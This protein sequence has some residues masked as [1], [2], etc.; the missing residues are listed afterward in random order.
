MAE[1]F[2]D[3][4]AR[5]YRRADGTP[6]SELANFKLSIRVLRELYGTTT[7]A[8]FSP[9]KLK[10]VRNKMIETD[11]CRGVINQRIGRIKSMFKWAVQEE[12]IPETVYRALEC[13]RGIPYGRGE[14]RETE[15]VG[16]VPESYVSA[17]K[18]H[19]LPTVS[20]MI[21]IQRLT[22]MRPGEVCA[23]RAIDIETSGTVWLYRPSQHKTAWRG[24]KRVIALGPKAQ[25]IVREFLTT[26]TQSHLFSPRRAI[27]EHYAALRAERKSKVQPSQASRA[28]KQPEIEPG[29]CY[30]NESY[31]RAI[32]R[33]CVKADDAAREEA[34]KAALRAG[35]D[36]PNEDVVFVPHWHPNQLRHLHATEVRRQFG[37]EAA[38]VTLGHSQ[39][40]V[41]EIYAE[42]N[43]GLAVQVASKIG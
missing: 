12:I 31:A 7:A 21:E 6:T 32:A 24:R 11:L 35:D 23:M 39:A 5:Y 42:R 8:A 17:I 9:L 30:T 36:P 38:Q 43:L 19:V 33:G 28:K 34:T 15:P 3:R 41:T 2:L 16:P 13:V 29:D 14:A 37:L 10:A 40:Q 18:A 4:A 25:A 27:G 26:D 20:A 22:G 1:R